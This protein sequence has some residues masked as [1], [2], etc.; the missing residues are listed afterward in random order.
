MKVIL[1][2]ATSKI[3][4]D[5]LFILSKMKDR[6]IRWQFVNWVHF[7]GQD[8][9]PQPLGVQVIFDATQPTRVTANGIG[10]LSLSHSDMKHLKT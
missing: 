3:G 10:A 9:K 8:V 2:N 7:S 5:C 6:T 1:P 4:K